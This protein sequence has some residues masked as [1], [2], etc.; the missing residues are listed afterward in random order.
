[1]PIVPVALIDSF[2]P[3][4]SN[5]I[6]KT[7]VKIIYLKP[8]YYEDYKD[9]KSTEIAALV[10]SRIQQTINDTLGISSNQ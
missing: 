2:I 7:T 1:M 10:A 3:F 6:R 5:S 4:D 9:L 8:L